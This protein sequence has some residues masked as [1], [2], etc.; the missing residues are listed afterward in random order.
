MS[1]KTEQTLVLIKDMNREEVNIVWDQCNAQ[2]DR[3]RILDMLQFKEGDIVTFTS[4]RGETITGT[5]EKINRKTVSVKPLEGFRT[6]RVGPSL[7]TKIDTSIKG[8]FED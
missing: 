1:E 4:R 5:I 8:L 7:L 3:L 2:I 6:W